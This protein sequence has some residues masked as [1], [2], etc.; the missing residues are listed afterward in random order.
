MP[1]MRNNII[2]IGQLL[3]KAYTM[4]TRTQT[5]RV[6]DCNDRLILKALFSK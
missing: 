5:I 4:K 6:F 1:N 2:S 3:Q